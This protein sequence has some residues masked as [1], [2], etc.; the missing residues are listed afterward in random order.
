MEMTKGGMKLVA[1]LAAT[2][3]LVSSA[4]LIVSMRAAS[5]PVA[6]VRQAQE[7]AA[8][9]PVTER[10]EPRT[11]KTRAVD[12]QYPDGWHVSVVEDAE[13]AGGPSTKIRL[14]DGP[15]SAYYPSDAP[16]IVKVWIQTITAD[17]AIYAGYEEA[18]WKSFESKEVTV[19]GQGATQFIAEAGLDMELV[20]A[21][22]EVLFIS[23]PTKRI[24]VHYE[25]GEAADAN[26]PAWQMI[27]NSLK[28]K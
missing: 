1:G 5:E 9:V 20:P 16:G 3:V 21:F 22:E 14:N 26:D 25:Y 7:P 19:N 28:V 6:P 2:A 10:A 8:Q 13:G 11:L 12:F 18:K 15:L 23:G 27:K 24:E 4:N 17:S